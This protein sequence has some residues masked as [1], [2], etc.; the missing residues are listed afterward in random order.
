[1]THEITKKYCLWPSSLA[2]TSTA[3]VS[4]WFLWFNVREHPK[5]QPPVVLVLKGLRRRGHSLKS[6]PTDWEKP[7]I[8]PV[9]PGGLQDI[10]LSPTP[11]RVSKK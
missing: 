3:G 1:M 10:G 8:K 5:A 6:H 7:G 4:L 9:T 2:L 11:W